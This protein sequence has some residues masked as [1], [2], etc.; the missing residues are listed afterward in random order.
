MNY[1]MLL[2]SDFLQAWGVW[3]TFCRTRM[4]DLLLAGL[5]YTGCPIWKCP[6]LKSYCG[7]IF[8]ARHFSL[9]FLWWKNWYILIFGINMIWLNIQNLDLTENVKNEPNHR[10]L[11]NFWIVFIS[12]IKMYTFFHHKN[13]GE[14][15][16]PPK[17]KSQ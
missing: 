17:M 5:G 6:I 15:C 14:K 7:F 9:S 11:W 3:C 13:D 1:N 16:L 4:C 8:G 10:A 12:N 2:Y